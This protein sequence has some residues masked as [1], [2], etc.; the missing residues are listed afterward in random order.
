MQ[1]SS[2]TPGFIMVF[3]PGILAGQAGVWSWCGGAAQLLQ[4]I[5]CLC[6]AAPSHHLA[7]SCH[8]FGCTGERSGT[9]VLSGLPR[10]E[11]PCCNSVTLENEATASGMPKAFKNNEIHLVVRDYCNIIDQKKQKEHLFH[12][13]MPPHPSSFSSHHTVASII[14]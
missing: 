12:Q 14:C 13:Y 2:F 5:T 4:G 3:F 11:G 7:P 1:S 10:P 8:C 6:P 9:A